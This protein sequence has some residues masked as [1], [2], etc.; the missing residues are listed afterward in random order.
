MKVIMLKTIEKVGKQGEVVNVKRGFAR[1][2]L[3][4][5]KLAIYATQAILKNLDNIQ[6]KFA[7]EEQ[8]LRL[9]K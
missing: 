2:Y 4:P 9:N 1:N 7:D 5:K 6:S 3:V 8:K